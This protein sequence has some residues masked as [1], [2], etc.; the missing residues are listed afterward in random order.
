MTF[1]AQHLKNALGSDLI[2]IHHVLPPRLHS[3]CHDSRHLNEPDVYIAIK[4]KNM[5][6][7]QFIKDAQAKGAVAALVSDVNDE[8]LSLNLP[9][10]QVKH[11]IT[12]LHKLAS[13][14]LQQMPALKIAITGSQGKT[15]TKEL[16]RAAFVQCLGLKKVFASFGNN[17]NQIGLPLNALKVKSQHGVA[18]FELGTNEP[19]EIKIL[20][21]IVKPD[22]ALITNV[23]NAHS[24]YLKNPAGIAQEK[25]DIYQALSSNGWAIVNADDA[26]CMEQ[27]QKSR[28]KIFLFGESEKANLRLSDVKTTESGCAFN[29]SLQN[30]T[31][32]CRIHLLGAHMAKNATAALALCHC[33]GLNISDATAGF[34]YVR[35]V[36]RRLQKMKLKNDVTL[37]DDTY[38]ASPE[39]MRYALEV[40]T[41]HEGLRKIAI[42]GDMRE[43]DQE[44]KHHYDLGIWCA[45]NKVDK[46]F[47][48]GALAQNTANGAQENGMNP[49][50]ISIFENSSDLAANIQT[51]IQPGDILLVKGSKSMQMNKIC[52]A[53]TDSM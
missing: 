34:G 7:H 22:I 12:A 25:G 43:L 11:T 33:A 8:M 36:N 41:L 23:G 1:N 39:S 21:N 24:L 42:L 3:F 4:G 53:L 32:A 17:N 18:I 5:D 13:Y 10:I 51:L 27:A 35:F 46:L 6:G 38:N 9:L 49:E 19:G 31:T 47:L 40:L 14:H 29:V 16:T 52:H 20:A 48:C 45:Q 2:A 50:D 30:K 44:A 28:A 15:S 26:L 37:I